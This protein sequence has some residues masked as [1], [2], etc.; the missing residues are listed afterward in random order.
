MRFARPNKKRRERPAKKPASE[1]KAGAT[2]RPTADQS[3][4]W[5][6]AIT[7]FAAGAVM[8]YSAS[9]AT[10]AL[11]TDGDPTGYLKRYLLIGGV[12]LIL[13]RFATRIDLNKVREL[14]PI[15]MIAAFSMLVLVLLP[16][17]GV[18]INGAKRWLGSGALRFQ[19]SEVMK[20]A[21]VLYTAM[22]VAQKPGRVRDLKS[23]SNPLFY[24]IGAAAFL[25]ALQPDLGTDLVACAT[26]GM[27]LVA[28]GARLQDLA[29]VVG[30]LAIVVLVFS[31]VE[32]YRMAR[33]TA[34]INPDGDPTGIG[35]QSEQARI[36]IG[37]GGLFGVGL[38]ESVQKVFY[39][40]EAHTD[41][42]LA[43]IGEEL[44]LMGIAALATLYFALVVAGLRAAKNS[45]DVYARLLAIGITSMIA[46]QALLNFFAVLGMAPLTGVPLP[47]ISYGGANL[48]V[49]L[50][51]MGL[52][53][54]VASGQHVARVRVLSGGGQRSLHARAPRQERAKVAAASGARSSRSRGHYEDR[55]RSGR[56]GGTR[57]SGPGRR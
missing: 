5:T 41:M 16:G 57:R 10:S 47:F 31:L 7:L 49:M 15:L 17:F 20:L 29:K 4:L 35:Y 27:I 24:V 51:A 13:M 2:T 56:N 6:V 32:P 9:S 3:L 38:G 11:Q 19:P 1:A 53:I 12:G 39:M 55:S 37:S 30:V 36:A 40:P 46:C 8:V 26:I 28:A 18:E 23:L 44:G 21:L 45:R 14:T 52:L 48:I 54:N 42:I 43:V 25:I 34:F 50:V 33:L 22:L